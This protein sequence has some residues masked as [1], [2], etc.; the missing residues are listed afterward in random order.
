MLWIYFALFAA[1]LAG[2][3]DITAKKITLLHP[4]A[5]NSALIAFSISGIFSFI[6]LLCRYKYTY[7]NPQEIK[8]NHFCYLVLYAILYLTIQILFWLSIKHSS[9]P[10]YTRLIYNTNVLFTFILACLFL[11]AVINFRILF[12][13]MITFIGLSIVSTSYKSRF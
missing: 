11:N 6:V 12:G 9:N 1:V 5:I 10:G 3:A 13:V 7:F 4:K 8:F 2:F